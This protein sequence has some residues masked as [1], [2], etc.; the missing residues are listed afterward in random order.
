MDSSRW[1]KVKVAFNAAND[2]PEVERSAFLDRC[3]EDLRQ[4]IEHL[5]RASDEA[6]AFINE[7]AVVDLGLTGNDNL[8]VYIGKEIDSYLIVRVIAHGG[9]GTV[10]LANR[11][12]AS[13]EKQFAIKVIKRGMDTNAVLKR[14]MMERQILAQ[15]QHPNIANLVDGG[16]TA[17]GVPYFV[18]EY[19]EG[20]PVNKFCDEHALDIDERLALFRKICS[21]ISYAHQNLIVHRDLKPSNIMVTDDGTPKLLDFGIAKLLRPDW[22]LD[23]NEATATM[24][25]VMTPEYASPEQLCGQPI[26]TASDVYSLGV[27]LYELLCGRRPIKIEGRL[28]E[29][30]AKIVWTEEP[31]KPSSVVSSNLPVVED[32]N[33]ELGRGTVVKPAMTNSRSLRGDLDNIILKALAKESERRYQSVHE[34]SEDI[35]RHLEGMPVTATAD[36]LSYRLAKFTKRHRTVV[37]AGVFVLFTLI[38]ATSVTTWQTVVAKRERDRAERRFKDV[39]N[40]ANS[41][42]FDFHDSIADLKGATK[43]REMVV[44]TAQEYLDSLSQEAGDDPE[45]LWELST[46]YLK[47]G[48]AQ[49]RPGFSRTGDTGAAFE[50]YERSLDLRRRLVNKEPTNNE[51]Q[52]GLAITLSR[53]GPMFQVLGKPDMAVERMLDATEI[54]DRLLP[55]SH[56]FV[57]F[58]GAT[59]N[60]AFLGDALTETGNYAEALN[61]YQRCLSTAEQGR[62]SFSDEEVD[63]RIAV[64]R[65]RLGFIFRIKGDYQKSL[66]NQMA[67]VAIEEALSSREPTNDEY[68]RSEAT[69]LDNAGDAFRGLKNYPKA[70]EFGNR[71]LAMYADLLAKEPENARA[72]KDVGDCSHHVAETLLA[73]GDYVD[74]LALLQKT[75]S[76]RRD[77]VSADENNVEYRDD[78]ANS[79]MLTG[80]A[81]A[82]SRNSAKSV[83]V[84][85]EAASVIQS[86]VSL[87]PQRID[88]RRQLARLY[89]DLGDAFASLKRLDK[90]RESYE[91]SAELWTQLRDRNALWAEDIGLSKNAD[92]RV[93]HLSL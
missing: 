63:H 57:T 9:M 88:Y 33:G 86:M 10:Y 21:V 36:S 2:L 87:Y 60:L 13:F 45:L 30:A 25:R 58:Q 28:P 56:D 69:A 50:S 84:Y 43:A 89:A 52:L 8:D 74:A 93:R 41:F 70:L 29:E 66:D 12:D 92:E 17:D 18:M 82:A 42:L 6:G 61:V 20:S 19:V 72:K 39:R 22:S 35:R 85:E 55:R 64:C 83:E 16:T 67:M 76:V 62:G 31:L 38:A 37:V 7:P 44:K 48:D 26:T 68:G 32:T 5:L 15:L 14:F 53:F 54:T 11:S 75:V 71:G 65:E 49:G 51:Y 47:L 81:L 90:A 40:L 91:K 77:L 78:V 80:E 73:K 24:F 1:S 79:L 23:T 4:E 34:F 46:A 59:R 3:D 27:V